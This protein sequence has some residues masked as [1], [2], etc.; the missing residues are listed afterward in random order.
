MDLDNEIVRESLMRHGI[1]PAVS[2]NIRLGETGTDDEPRGLISIG[3]TM[4]GQWKETAMV[5]TPTREEAQLFLEDADRLTELLAL[6]VRAMPGAE[7]PLL[8][9]WVTRNAG[10]QRTRQSLARA[11]TLAENAI[12]GPTKQTDS[13][14]DPNA[15]F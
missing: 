8:P 7:R 11:K 13:K 6:G 9:Y 14:D 5:S 3:Y 12:D 2:R 15:P 10:A 1:D 4:S